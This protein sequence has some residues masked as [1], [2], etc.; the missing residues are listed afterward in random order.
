MVPNSHHLLFYREHVHT[1]FHGYITN[2]NSTGYFEFYHQDRK[3]SFHVSKNQRRA[4]TW[5]CNY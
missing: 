2:W 4:V 1:A 3:Y 5:S